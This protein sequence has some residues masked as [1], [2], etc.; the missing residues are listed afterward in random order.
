[1]KRNKGFTLIELMIA[2][3]I[4][5]ILA[6]ITLVVYQ[7]FIAKSQ[8][9][10]VH[11]ELAA[12]RSIVEELVSSGRSGF[13]N[14]EIGYI[15]SGLVLPGDVASFATD[16][17]GVLSVTIGGAASPM[18]TGARLLIRRAVDGRWSCEIDSTG[19]GNWRTSFIPAGCS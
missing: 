6:A 5:G 11:A 16:G 2:I 19:A 15:Q 18:V 10:R 13:T 3:A 12:Y 7:N 4:I 1:M 9:G 8:V 17:S 14:A